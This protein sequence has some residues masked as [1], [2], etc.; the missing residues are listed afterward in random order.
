MMLGVNWAEVVAKGY[1]VPDGLNPPDALDE[2]LRMLASPD[3]EIRDTQAYSVLAVWTRAG[4]FDAVL[5]ELGDR[6]ASNLGDSSV[7]VRSFS[8]LILG[9]VVKRD[10]RL[11]VTTSAARHMWLTHWEFSYPYE[12]DVRSYDPDLGWIHTVAHGADLAREFALHPSISITQGYLQLILDVL[13]DRLRSLTLHL[14]QT[15]EDRLALAMLAVLSRPEL[16]PED[17]RQWLTDYRTLWTPVTLPLSPGPALA[18]RTL[19][20]LHSLLYLGATLDGV[21][22]RPAYPAE[23][24]TAVQEALRSFT[25]YLA[26]SQTA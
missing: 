22:L 5:R 1:A 8:A 15:E 12:Q 23:A 17:I 16:E 11:L 26:D 19:H 9:E 4:H 13:V 25:P 24:L 21:T 7:L 3:P 20:S 14:N 6:V 2:L 18:I 10:A